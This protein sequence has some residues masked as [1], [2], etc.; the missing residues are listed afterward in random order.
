VMMEYAASENHT[1]SNAGSPRARLLVHC[2]DF[3]CGHQII[4]GP[5]DVDRWPND[6]RLFDLEPRPAELALLVN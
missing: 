2:A 6:V 1:Q 4:M 5:A 3:R